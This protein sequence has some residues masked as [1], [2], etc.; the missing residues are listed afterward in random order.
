MARS[1]RLSLVI[2]VVASPLAAVPAH[3]GGVAAASQTQ[4]T[5]SINVP[6]TGR[7]SNRRVCTTTRLTGSRFPQRTCR[8]QADIDADRQAQEDNLRDYQHN[9]M[10]RPGEQALV[11][12]GGQTVGPN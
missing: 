2:A 12:P 11:G 5:S 3:A 10:S 4:P 6:R 7:D 8:T 1:F 9:D